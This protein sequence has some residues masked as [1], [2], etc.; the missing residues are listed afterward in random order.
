MLKLRN[1]EE[2]FERLE[3]LAKEVRKLQGT[4]DAMTE[5]VGLREQI[6]DLKKKITD[7]KIDESRIKE[8]HEREKRETTHQVG[9]ERMRQ[10]FEV[11]QARREA[12]V[13]VREENL[14][15]DRERFETQ[16]KFTT[17]RFET[18]VGY[19]KDLMRELMVR[20]PTVKVD[21]EISGNGHKEPEAA[22]A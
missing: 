11:N 3:A 7:L 1:E 20:L 15:A 22:D 19:L 8:E 18:E 13:A 4:R 14:Q 6:N 21:R 16:M 9:L 2:L 17:E 5:E 10:E 12:M